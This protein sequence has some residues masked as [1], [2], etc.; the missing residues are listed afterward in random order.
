[1]NISIKT[2]LSM[3]CLSALCSAQTVTYLKQSDFNS[4][5][6]RIKTPGVFIF[7][8]NV[9]FNPIPAAEATR[10]DKPIAGWFAAITVETN[11]V[12]IDLNHKTLEASLD[13]INTHFFTVF[14]NIE[15]DNSPFPGAFFGLIGASFVGDTTYVSANNVEIKNGTIGRSSHWGIHGNVNNNLDIHDLRI[16]DFEVAGMEINSAID[17][18]I[19]DIKISGNEHLIN[20]TPMHVA[21]YTLLFYLEALAAQSYPGA[22]AQVTSLQNYIT[23]HPEIFDTPAVLPV[24]SY[25]GI[26]MTSG[27][28]FIQPFPVTPESCATGAALSGGRTINNVKLKNIQIS[29]L[30]NAPQSFTLI[31]SSEDN[32]LAF[33]LSL[34]GLPAFGA[35]RWI[36]AFDANGNFAPNP[37]LLAQI[38]AVNSQIVLHPEFT[39]SLAPNY[40]AIAAA[41]ETDDEAAFLAE[42]FPILGFGL[43]GLGLAGTFAIRFDCAQDSYLKNINVCNIRNT[44]LPAATLADIPDGENYPTGIETPYGGN[45]TWAYEFANN[46]NVTITK[47]NANNVFSLNGDSFGLDFAGSDANMNA[48]YCSQKNIIGQSDNAFSV[49]NAASTAYGVRIQNNLGACKL[50]HVS[51]SNITAP[52]FAF[53]FASEQSNN[54]LFTRCKTKNV[55]TTSSTFLTTPSVHKEAFGFDLENASNTTIACARIN[56]IETLGES[57]AI[58]SDSVAAGISIDDASANTIVISPRISTIKGGA[59]Q[60]VKI[61]NHGT[62]TVVKKGKC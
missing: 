25:Y 15:L 29:N 50:S 53:G 11:D 39:G 9:E 47:C 46:N 2:S 1:M 8:E 16:K 52:R 12:I 27:F 33:N 35:G 59:G 48:S 5:T 26:E 54:V 19:H 7:E 41:I 22:A 28:P 32:G 44:G 42:T 57:G 55:A 31:G 30:A 51:V 38:F 60:A 17:S 43:D 45:D 21:G 10:T 20:N 61:D 34:I 3:L 14:A 56:G 24:S 62:N 58:R 49:V 40:P 18:Y 37:F 4:G 13:Y 6:Y 36:D 23:A